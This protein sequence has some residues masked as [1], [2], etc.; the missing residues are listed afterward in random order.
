MLNQEWEVPA[1][2]QHAPNQSTSQL[3]EKHGFLYTASS[4]PSLSTHARMRAARP[5]LCTLCAKLWVGSAQSLNVCAHTSKL[6]SRKEMAD[7]G[8][9]SLPPGSPQCHFLQAQTFLDHPSSTTQRC[10]FPRWRVC[11]TDAGHILILPK[12]STDSSGCSTMLLPAR[13]SKLQSLPALFQSARASQTNTT[14]STGT[15]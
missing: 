7:T 4:V 2:G 8:N 1:L 15:P 14:R 6:P 13:A 3:Q 10:P 11:S 5:C 9:G 12:Y